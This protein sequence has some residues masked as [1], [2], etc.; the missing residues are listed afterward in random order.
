MNNPLDIIT[1]DNIMYF[2]MKMLCSNVFG[3]DEKFGL[4]KMANV[5]F[6]SAFR[7]GVDTCI[8]TCDIYLNP[9]DKIPSKIKFNLSFADFEEIDKLVEQVE[10]YWQRKNLLSGTIKETF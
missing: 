10:Y 2:V 8:I 3:A 9:Y 4:F 7:Y 1:K 5:R 6:D